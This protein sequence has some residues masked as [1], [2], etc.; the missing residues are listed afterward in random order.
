MVTRTAL[1]MAAAAAIF[2]GCG[3]AAAGSDPG[4]FLGLSWSQSSGECLNQRLC[5]REVIAA[6]DSIPGETILRANAQS[7][8]GIPLRFASLGF[9][10]D[11]F[12]LGTMV[13]KPQVGLVDKL[14]RSLE[15]QF[16]RPRFE[17]AAALD[18]TVGQTKITLSKNET[19]CGIVYAHLPVYAVVAKAKNLPRPAG[20]PGK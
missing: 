3:S 1:W 11:R 17:N 7:Y 9:Y 19:V 12:Y 15:Q 5:T 10:N 14:R 4:G 18:W 13:F 2:L 8:A 16:G 6:E 20:A